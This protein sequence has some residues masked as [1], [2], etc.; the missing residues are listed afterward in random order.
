LAAIRTLHRLVC[1]LEA[2]HDALNQ[3]SE[4]APAWV[5]QQV[6]PAWYTRD[7]LRSDQARLL[8]DASNR[9]ALARQIGADGY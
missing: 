1:V 4:A 6:P 5:R 2:R 3:L 9:E 8:T 7:G